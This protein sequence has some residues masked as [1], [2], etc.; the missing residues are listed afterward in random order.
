MMEKKDINTK[1]RINTI[2]DV[3][4]RAADGNFNVSIPISKNV[5]ELDAIAAG[6]NMMIEEVKQRTHEFETN[7][8]ELERFNK[9][10]IGRELKMVELKDR[11]NK[12]ENMLKKRES[13][14]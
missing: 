4:Q 10:A 8:A 7:N 12:L 14:T 5:D 13:T 1:G 9:I 2:L 6:I 3:L 11:I